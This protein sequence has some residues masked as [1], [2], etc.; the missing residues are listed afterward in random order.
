[1]KN[2]K[3]LEVEHLNGLQPPL[4][5]LLVTPV[6]FML[7]CS[8]ASMQPTFSFWQKQNYTTVNFDVGHSRK[9]K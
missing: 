1:M 4:L 5:V 8:K 6:P 9:I 7:Y 2:P 3:E